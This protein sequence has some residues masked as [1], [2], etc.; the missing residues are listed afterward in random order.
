LNLKN[1]LGSHKYRGIKMDKEVQAVF[2]DRD[3]T[4]G[5]TGHFIHPRDFELY[6]FASQAIEILKE[7]GLKV[8]ALTNQHRIARGEATE[9]E[10]KKQFSEFGFDESYICP[11]ASNSGCQCH[12]PEPGLLHRAAK[13]HN[14]DLTKCIVI[15]DVGSTDMLAADAVGSLKIL[16]RT[17]WGE[18][19]LGD[20]RHTWAEV[21]PDYVAENILDAIKWIVGK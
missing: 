10:F 11:H 6:P 9:E 8:F 15:G 2:I 14:L 17:G 3:G 16:V 18:D 4:I 5:G 21:D 12:K 7:A 19:S 1:I 20:F 13:E